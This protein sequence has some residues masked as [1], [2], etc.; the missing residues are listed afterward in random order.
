ML[1]GIGTA[2]VNKMALV[3]TVQDKNLKEVRRA[4]DVMAKHPEEVQNFVAKTAVIGFQDFFSKTLI[5]GKAGFE[6]D[7]RTAEKIYAIMLN[8]TYTKENLNKLSTSKLKGMMKKNNQITTGLSR[9]DIVKA[10]AEI[11]M[12]I[13]FSKV[14]K[15]SPAWNLR[16]TRLTNKKDIHK[17]LKSIRSNKFDMMLNAFIDFALSKE[18]EIN[19]YAQ[20]MD[21]KWQTPA[22]LYK[23]LGHIVQALGTMHKA[24]GATMS[25]GEAWLRTVTL[26][27]GV[28][29]AQ[30]LG[31]VRPDVNFW[32]LEGDEFRAASAI[33]KLVS[34]FSNMGL[35][36]TDMAS[37]GWGGVGRIMQKFNI[38]PHQKR[39]RD[40]RIIKYAYIIEKDLKN[41][42]KFNGKAIGK[43]IV[44]AAKD[45]LLF[46]KWNKLNLAQ[47]QQAQ[48]LKFIHFGVTPALFLDLVLAGPLGS[49]VIFSALRKFGWAAG[50]GTGIRGLPSPLAQIIS[51]PLAFAL[52][53]VKD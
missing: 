20:I 10:L 19:R 44:K 29:K 17:R 5:N 31:Y 15:D 1:G 53:P 37:S 47:Q 14:I 21:W 49:V 27:V 6:M 40:A 4:L 35:S 51:V 18:Y 41:L 39:G 7:N 12:R 33:G 32:E 2:Y 23:G 8:H 38:W 9:D 26:I 11:E 43:M 50:L 24:I 42:G 25:D 34:E 3:H 13:Q 36:T 22:N 46:R 48:L 30:D 45:G 16:I 52:R 28:H